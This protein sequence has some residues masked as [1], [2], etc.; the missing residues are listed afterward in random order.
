VAHYAQRHGD[1]PAP[2]LLE[3]VGVVELTDQQAKPLRDVGMAESSATL[4]VAQREKT[5]DGH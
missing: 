5:K 1:I 2:N 4:Q 3:L